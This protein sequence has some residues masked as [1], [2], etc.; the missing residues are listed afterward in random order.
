MAI[1]DEQGYTKEEYTQA[2][3]VAGTT[4]TV[5]HGINTSKVARIH[6]FAYNTVNGYYVENGNPNS[7][8]ITGYSA[9]SDFNAMLTNTDWFIDVPVGSTNLAGATIK[10]I[11][12][13]R[14]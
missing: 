11:I 8:Q 9:T 14:P 1:R 10:I 13:L 2:A 7:G 4:Y 3:V 5:A 12:Y 6:S